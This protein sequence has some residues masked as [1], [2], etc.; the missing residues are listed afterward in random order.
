MSI[1]LETCII[2]QHIFINFIECRALNYSKAVIYIFSSKLFHNWILQGGLS[3]A[4]FVVSLWFVGPFCQ[5]F[6]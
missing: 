4:K 1:N 5:E 3:A 6:Y 2:N